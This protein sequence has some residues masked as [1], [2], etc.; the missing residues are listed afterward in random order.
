MDQKT[1]DR[2]QQA[3]ETAIK[4]FA[5]LEAQSCAA[6]AECD[7]SKTGNGYI[8]TALGL[9]VQAKGVATHGINATPDVTANFG[10]K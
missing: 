9:L 3:L 8:T 7:K 2:A 6:A 10:G 1:V 5:M 4:R